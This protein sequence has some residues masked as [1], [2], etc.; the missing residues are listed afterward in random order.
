MTRFS[1]KFG[2]PPPRELLEM[3]RGEEGGCG[4][5]FSF[6]S[7]FDPT[8]S[9]PSSPPLHLRIIRPGGHKKRDTTQKHRTRKGRR[10]KKFV[11]NYFEAER[12]RRRRL[13]PARLAKRGKKREEVFP[14]FF[15]PGVGVGMRGREKEKGTGSSRKKRRKAG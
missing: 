14:F 1:W 11:G 3:R 5:P 6:S 13:E 15:L 12:R 4:F 8:P 7:L 10:E 2:G 9:P